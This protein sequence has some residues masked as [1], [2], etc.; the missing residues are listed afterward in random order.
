LTND[1][2]ASLVSG[3]AIPVKRHGLSGFPGSDGNGGFSDTGLKS[4]Y[5]FNET[6]G[7]IVNQS[8]SDDTLGTGANITITG[9]TYDDSSA[10]ATFNASMLYDGVNDYGVCGVSKSQWNFLHNTSAVW[11]EVM[12]LRLNDSFPGGEPSL[13]ADGG[14]SASSVGTDIY[15]SSTKQ[16]TMLITNGTDVSIAVSSG[17]NYVPDVTNWHFYVFTYDYSLGSNN[18]KMKRDND[19]LVQGSGSSGLVDDNSS[20]ALETMRNPRTGSNYINA[21][22]CEWSVWNKVLSDDD[23]TLLWNDGDGMEIY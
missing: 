8:E 23:Q 16:L 21:Y 11:S 7:A 10:P 5:K 15:C 18:G 6:S 4:Y 2:L 19:N 14:A 3:S 12:W 22:A 1:I 17:D 9:A 20:Y 13:L